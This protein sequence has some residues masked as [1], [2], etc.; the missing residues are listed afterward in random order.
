MIRTATPLLQCTAITKRF[1]GETALDGVDFSLQTG[2]VHGLVGSN[3]AGKSTLMKILAGAL[4][5]HGGQ[6]LLNGKPTT[7]GNPLQAQHAGIAMVYQELS[8]VG[9]MSVAENLFLGRQP[10]TRL[11]R[12]DWKAMRQQAAEYLAEID[13]HVDV[14]S[15]LDS[16]P[17]VIRQMVEIAR[18]LHSGA[19][20]LILDEPTSALSPPETRRLFDLIAQLKQRGVAVIFISHFIEDVLEIC[21]RVT[22][23]RD[24]RRVETVRS[25]VVDKHTLIHTML[26]HALNR[27]ATACETAVT[28]PPQTE[29]PSVLISENLQLAG[30]FS[31][32]SIKV[33]PG[34]CLG[35]YGFVGAGHQELAHVIAG[36]RKQDEGT[37]LFDGCRM[38]PGNTHR[39]VQKGIVL[40]AADRG[41]T[42]VGGAE[43]YKNATLAHLKRIADKWVTSGREITAVNPLLER[44][45]CKPAAPRMRAGDLSGGNQQK[46]VLSKW[47]LGD[48]RVLVLEEPTRGM[49]VGAKEEIMQL[50][51]ELKQRGTAVILASTEPELLLEHAD[52]IAVFRRGTQT[53]EFSNCELDKAT[54]MRHA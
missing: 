9:Q 31:N 32:V 25:E 30:T 11:G 23:L 8:G 48:V 45:G 19:R 34:E 2:E 37:I 50:V 29:T 7:L 6:V 12:I 18:G 39:A 17:L 44:V 43:I 22:V 41:Q 15:R 26:G 4:P 54:L 21:D 42:L 46:V 20:I 5:D 38:K 1:G 28:L 33:A 13:I 47:L 52:R 35:L 14:R 49:D 3:G 36:A 10:T 27:T 24:G 40:V 16:H 53:A 51:A